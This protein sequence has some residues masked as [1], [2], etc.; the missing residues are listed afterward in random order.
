MKHDGSDQTFLTRGSSVGWSPDSQRIA[1][2]RSASGTG[3]PIKADPGAPTSRRG[4][5]ARERFAAQNVKRM[6]NWPVR[7]TAP[8]RSAV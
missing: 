1:F 6:P 5:A 2:H 3:L 8:A 4:S 7:G